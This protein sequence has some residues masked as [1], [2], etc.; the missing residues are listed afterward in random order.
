MWMVGDLKVARAAHVDEERVRERRRV[1]RRESMVV[2]SGVL[3]V[4]CLS[5]V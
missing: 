1:A 5:F 3:V 4:G 2:W